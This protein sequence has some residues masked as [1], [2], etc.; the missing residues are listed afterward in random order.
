MAHRRLLLV[1]MLLLLFTSS[2]SCRKLLK[3]PDSG[4]GKEFSLSEMSLYLSALPKGNV[5][6]STPSKKSHSLITDE[7]LIVR[8]LISID[9]IL[10]SVPSPGV[11][12]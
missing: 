3:S 11:G 12:H 7:K 1:F 9:R 5:P 10:R 6:T 4:T 2:T 8:H